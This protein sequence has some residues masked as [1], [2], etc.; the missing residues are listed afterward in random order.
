M[1]IKDKTKLQEKC[2]PI[3]IK[4]GEEFSEDLFIN[5]LLGDIIKLPGGLL[6]IS[7]LCPS[8]LFELEL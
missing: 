7:K 3:S 5:K 1:I 8:R 4:E 2:S 6:E